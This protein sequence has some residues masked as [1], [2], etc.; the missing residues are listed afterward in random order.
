MVIEV[1]KKTIVLTNRKKREK[2][3]IC[4]RFCIWKTL[5]IKEKTHTNTTV[6]FKVTN[7]K[8]NTHRKLI[9]LMC[10]RKTENIMKKKTHWGAWVAQLVKC[11]TFE[12]SSDLDLKVVS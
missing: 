1:S 9:P 11:Q 4:Q 3:S 2:H 12:L 5:K 10:S 7:Y 8:I 6:S